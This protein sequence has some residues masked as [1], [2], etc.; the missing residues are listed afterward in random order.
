MKTDKT[1]L[2]E[3]NWSPSGTHRIAHDNAIK[4]LSKNCYSTFSDEAR[5]EAY[6]GLFR[7][8]ILAIQRDKKVASR[9]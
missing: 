5:D 1:H 8:E 9:T 6:E 7:E 2:L 4:R 3:P